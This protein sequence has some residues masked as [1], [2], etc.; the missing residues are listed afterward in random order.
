MMKKKKK[1]KDGSE[2]VR[3]RPLKGKWNPRNFTESEDES[4]SESE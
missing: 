3:M 4:E 1:K 2:R